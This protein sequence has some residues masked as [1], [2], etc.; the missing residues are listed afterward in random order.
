MDLL[1]IPSLISDNLS[2]GIYGTRECSKR[3]VNCE[4]HDSTTPQPLFGAGLILLFWVCL[5][6]RLISDRLER[7]E[8]LHWLQLTPP[9][10]SLFSICLPHRILTEVSKV[11]T[12]EFLSRLFSLGTPPP[13]KKKK[14]NM[15]TAMLQP[16]LSQLNV[17]SNYRPTLHCESWAMDLWHSSRDL[18]AAAKKSRHFLGCRAPSIESERRSP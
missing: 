1:N 15:A 12:T 5:F 2:R 4:Q 7:M 3:L 16:C 11:L 18:L 10:V 8:G 13:Q 14:V 17:C 9:E 6:H